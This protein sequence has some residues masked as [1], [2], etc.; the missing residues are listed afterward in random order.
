M[1]VVVPC[2]RA[3]GDWLSERVSVFTVSPS[4][5][6]R[7]VEPHRLRHRPRYCR[8]R[9]ASPDRESAG[10]KAW[11]FSSAYMNAML[12]VLGRKT[13]NLSWTGYPGI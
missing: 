1:N 13:E 4:A 9:L 5:D 7:M 6:R 2:K 11:F 8:I 3:N 10:L 12:A